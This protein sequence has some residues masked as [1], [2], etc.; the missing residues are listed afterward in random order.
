MLLEILDQNE[1]RPYQAHD[2]WNF[3]SNGPGYGPEMPNH[4]I[5]TNYGWRE[6]RDRKVVSF[7]CWVISEIHAKQDHTEVK[8]VYL[9]PGMLLIFLASLEMWLML[10]QCKIIVFIYRSLFLYSKTEMC[11]LSVYTRKSVIKVDKLIRWQKANIGE[12]IIKSQIAF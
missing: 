12:I 10:E 5:K 3:G 9:I 6:K 1:A 8:K 7:C 11:H 4:S 2:T